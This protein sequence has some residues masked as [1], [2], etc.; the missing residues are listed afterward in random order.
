MIERTVASIRDASGPMTR[1]SDVAEA[2]WRVANDPFVPL[3]IAAGADAEIWLAE[4]KIT[5]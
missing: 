1:S 5:S 3:R 4:A 2:I